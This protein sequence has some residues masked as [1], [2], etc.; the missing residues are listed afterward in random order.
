MEVRHIIDRTYEVKADERSWHTV[1]WRTP[2]KKGEGMPPLE[3]DESFEPY[4]DC[5]CP[6]DN[7]SEVCE[8]VAA[9]LK[10]EKQQT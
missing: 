3:E 4:F 10:Y 1:V 2:R 9:V 8:H 5:S 7:T 6:V